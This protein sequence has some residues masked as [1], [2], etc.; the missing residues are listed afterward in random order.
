MGARTAINLALVAVVAALA[1]IALRPHEAPPVTGLAISAAPPRE[2]TRIVIERPGR[3]ALRLE[4]GTQGWRLAAPIEAPADRYRVEALLAL[5]AAR[6]G[7]GFRASGNDLA[8]FGLDPARSVLRFDALV[9][10]LGD[11]EPISARRYLH[12][13]AEDQVH[14]I[15][16]RWFGHAFG[17]A[18]AWVDPRPLPAGAEPV[19]IVLPQATW[20]LER[21]AWRREPPDP[22]PGTG[23]GVALA[24]AW[25]RARALSVR[26]LD[27]SLAWRREVAVEVDGVAEPLRFVV[28]ED[29][30]AVLLARRDLGLQYRFLERQGRTLLGASA[31]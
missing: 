26:A 13:P 6:S 7:A 4:S 29:A 20:R 11:V 31:P 5:P 18:E 17:S 10:A 9:L 30:G 3:P 25:Q 22:A 23:A 21:G 2:V 14:L 27:P 28:A 24:E 15:E 19:R 8:E 16:D 12:N 1:W